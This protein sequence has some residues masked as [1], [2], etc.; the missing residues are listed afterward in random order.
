MKARTWPKLSEPLT[1]AC[2]AEGFDAAK[3]FPPPPT[4][5][6]ETK[7]DGEAANDEPAAAA[8]S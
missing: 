8:G 6:D 5:R 1:A 4:A 3:A 7:P 2:A